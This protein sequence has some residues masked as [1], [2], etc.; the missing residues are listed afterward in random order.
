M[1]IDTINDDMFLGFPPLAVKCKDIDGE[2][3]YKLD[4]FYVWRIKLEFEIRLLTIMVNG[5]P[6]GY[7]WQSLILNSG[8]RAFGAGGGPLAPIIV[9]GVPVASPVLLDPDGTYKPPGNNADVQARIGDSKYWLP[10]LN[11]P[12][13]VFANLGINPDILTRNQ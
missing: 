1:Y 8:F 4:Y 6:T 11:F 9:G 13:S 2:R 7:G 12:A 10:F 3:V 5:N